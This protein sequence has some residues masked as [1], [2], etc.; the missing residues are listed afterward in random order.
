[1]QL[2]IAKDKFNALNE[3]ETYGALLSTVNELD[4]NKRDKAYS[5]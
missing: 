2:L 3:S 5:Q 1:M 4:V